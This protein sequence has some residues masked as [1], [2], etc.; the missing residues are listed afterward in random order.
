MCCF[1]LPKRVDKQVDPR[2]RVSVGIFSNRDLAMFRRNFL[3]LILSLAVVAVTSSGI[4]AQPAAPALSSQPGAA[5]TLYLNF[6]GFD[7]TGNTW[8]GQSPGNVGAWR[9]ATGS[10]TTAQ[11]NEIQSIWARV[12][13][14]YAPFNVNVTTV[15]P[16]G[17]AAN[18]WNQRLNHYDNTPRLMHTLVTG[19]VPAGFQSGAGG[20]SYVDVWS[21]TSSSRQKTNWVFGNRMGY[22]LHDT[23]TATTHENGHAA[24]LWHQADVSTSGSGNSV[25]NHYSTNN[26]SST[27][28]PFMGVGYYTDG[29]PNTQNAWRVG[30]VSTGSDNSPAGDHNDVGRILSNNPGMGLYNDGIGQSLF[31]ATPLALIGTDIDPS[32]ANGVLVPTSPTSPNPNST[33]VGIFSFSTTGGLNTIQVHSGGQWITP[34]VADPG[35]TLDATLRILD[36]VGSQVAISATADLGELLSINLGA[37]DYYI[38]VSSAGVKAGNTN[39]G[40]WQPSQYY[41]IGSYFL[42]GSIA[43]VPE[44]NS[45]AA[46]LV[47]VFGLLV[48]RRRKAQ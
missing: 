23:Y 17:L 32:L 21:G 16:S 8:S 38:E 48:H 40:A 19:N 37:G 14:S 15:D 26:G 34:G 4:L 28:A 12:A 9:N 1:L 2:K 13:E 33:T 3:S 47:G 42:T 41:N 46:L 27:L 29:A 24:S 39:V 6:S 10:F 11:Q 30:R 5:Y 7:F 22:G 31:S 44:P 43:Y 36:D 20:V 18:Q 35:A 25:V 45:A